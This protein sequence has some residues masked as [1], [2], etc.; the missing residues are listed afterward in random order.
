MIRTRIDDEK[1]EETALAAGGG[2][3]K[4]FKGRCRNCGKYGHKAYHCRDGDNK[5]NKDNKNNN[6]N[7]KNS[8][9]KKY[10]FQGRCG[11]CNIYG[12]EEKDCRHKIKAQSKETANPAAEGAN[13]GVSLICGACDDAQD[14]AFLNA[15]SENLENL[16][17]ADSE[18]IIFSDDFE[19]TIHHLCQTE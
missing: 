1:H 5:D 6:N 11:F 9:D 3:F 13:E 8:Q 7:N 4:K 18:T 14:I 15:K 19:A 17:I 16:A 12:H 10:R 2:N